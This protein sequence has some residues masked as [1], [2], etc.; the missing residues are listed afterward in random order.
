MD[1]GIVDITVLTRMGGMTT[2]NAMKLQGITVLEPPLATIPLYPY[3]HKKHQALVPQIA[4][5]LRKMEARGQI[6]AIR[7]SETSRLLAEGG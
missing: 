6:E 5:V 3:L 1:L 4:E 2:L 7:K